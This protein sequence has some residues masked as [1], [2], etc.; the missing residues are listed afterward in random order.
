MLAHPG[1]MAASVFQIP[2]DV[3]KVAK[4]Q[5]SRLRSMAQQSA[6]YNL[7]R[8]YLEWIGDLHANSHNVEVVLAVP[9]SQFWGISS[10]LASGSIR[11][12]SIHVPPLHRSKA[13]VESAFFEGPMSDLG[14]GAVSSLS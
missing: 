9:A 1:A 12:V 10:A 7:T 4:K 6:E 13:V 14:G 5:L 8:T 11:F 3:E 2:P